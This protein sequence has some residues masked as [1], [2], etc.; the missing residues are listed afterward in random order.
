MDPEHWLLGTSTYELATK[1]NALNIYSL[2]YIF[3]ASPF[4][5]GGF[6]LLLRGRK[7]EA[8]YESQPTSQERYV[9]VPMT[10][11]RSR[12]KSENFFIF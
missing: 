3:L 12:S 9:P 1:G 10:R 5:G 7:H 2:P 4:V 11:V 8:M 6:F